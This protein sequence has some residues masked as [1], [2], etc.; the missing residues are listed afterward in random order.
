M[1]HDERLRLAADLTERLLERH[2]ATI[3]AVGVHGSVARGDDGE[4]SDLDL[5]V[6]TG[7]P[8][9]EVAARYLRHRGTVVDLGAIA[10]DAYLEEAGHIGPA[11]PLAAD[12]YV[13]HLAVHDPGGFFHKLKHVHEAAVEEAAPQVFAAA[14]GV[15]LV[16][17]L[18]WDAKARAAELAG[19]LLTTQ[20]AI[21]EVAILAALVVGLHTRSAYRNTAHA[22]H[23]T[24]TS[25]V[26]G[27]AFAEAY[28]R[29]LDPTVEPAFQ[30]LALGRA[31]DALLALAGRAGIP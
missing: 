23:A 11:W 26:A 9:V 16:Q 28:R 13:N 3:A 17:L 2:G 30:V 22:L 15:D 27:P 8:E 14:A 1:D 10:A 31:R 25:G 29:L 6:V 12:Q 4:E 21:K 7:G 24:A 5:A 20:V 18:S 19:D